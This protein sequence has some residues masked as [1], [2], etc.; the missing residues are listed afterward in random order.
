MKCHSMGVLH[1]KILTTYSQSA[2]KHKVFSR[3]MIPLRILF[4]YICFCS[5]TPREETFYNI[6]NCVAWYLGLSAWALWGSCRYSL[7]LC[8]WQWQKSEEQW[9]P[10]WTDPQLCSTHCPGP[11][12]PATC[13]RPLS[14][15][16]PGQTLSGLQQKHKL[17]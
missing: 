6:L 15:S 17:C 8:C 11:A 10:H 2:Q 9:A 12:E 16:S 7:H 13:S 14:W 5:L 4:V 3:I 1:L